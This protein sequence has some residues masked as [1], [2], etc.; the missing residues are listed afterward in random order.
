MD[1]R[2]LRRLLAFR[3]RRVRLRSPSATA[4]AGAR[5]RVRPHDPR[6]WFTSV[7]DVR[8]QREKLENGVRSIRRNIDR[9]AAAF[10]DGTLDAKT[11][12]NQKDRL[13]QDLVL[14]ETELTDTRAEHV[15]LEA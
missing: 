10:A 15:D 1:R 9:I 3:R 4:V 5:P 11:Y 8:E 13:D 12:Q 7:D 14:A 6:A 2:T